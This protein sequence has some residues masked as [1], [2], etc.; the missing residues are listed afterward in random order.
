VG[1]LL[2][3]VPLPF[4]YRPVGRC[5]AIFVY[6]LTDKAKSL[7]LSGLLLSSGVYPNKADVFRF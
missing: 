1:E 3:H 2:Y 7:I 5:A 4:G 6:V